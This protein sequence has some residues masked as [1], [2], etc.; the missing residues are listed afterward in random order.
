VT[1]CLHVVFHT[2]IARESGRFDIG[3]VI[4]GIQEK[5]IRRHPHVFS[6]TRADDTRT[7]IR[8]WEDLKMKEKERN[9]VLQG[10]PDTCRPSSRHSACRKRPLPSDSTGSPGK[11]RG[12]NL[13][14]R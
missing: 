2:E 10:V 3:D 1:C 11:K 8:N 5:L 13:P 7:V 6:D 14:K 4:Y 12:L 9:S